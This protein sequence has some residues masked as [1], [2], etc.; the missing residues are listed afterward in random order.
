MHPDDLAALLQRYHEDKCTPEER[1]IVEEWY[2]GLSEGEP[3]G[4]KEVSASLDKVFE[5]LQRQLKVR[6]HRTPRWPRMAAAAAVVLLAGAWWLLKKAPVKAPAYTEVAT[7]PGEIKRIALPD[8]SS[9]LLNANSRLR[10]GPSREARL[11]AGEAFFQ[12]APA[13]SRPFVVWAGNL[14]T[15]VLGTSFDI[16]SYGRDTAT[17]VAL[18]SGKVSVSAPGGEDLVLEPGDLATCARDGSRLAKGHF[19]DDRDITC[20]Q[21]HAISFRDASFEDIAFELANTYGLKLV[22]ASSRHDWSYTGYFGKENVWEIINTICITEHLDYQYD[23]GQ[24]ILVNK[25]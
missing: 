22:N 13:S 10:Y 17:V 2:Q 20:W 15:T 8:G 6:E 5:R 12:V 11:L 19:D 21:E 23:Q 14:R 18:L 24:V 16:R 3:S 9:V 4:E 1:R 7:V 25:K